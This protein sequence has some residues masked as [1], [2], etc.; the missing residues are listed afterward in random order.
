MDGT[1]KASSSP[2]TQQGELNDLLAITDS[3]SPRK[4]KQ[5]SVQFDGKVRSL[6]TKSNKTSSS[7][8]MMTSGPLSDEGLAAH[9][10]E[11][12]SAEFNR[13]RAANH[14]RK[15]DSVSNS[16]KDEF[17]FT[18]TLPKPWR[19]KSAKHRARDRRRKKRDEQ[20]EKALKDSEIQMLIDECANGQNYISLCDSFPVLKQ[21]HTVYLRCKNE[22]GEDRTE[23]GIASRD[24][25]EVA[26]VL[27]TKLRPTDRNLASGRRVL[28]DAEGRT[29]AYIF[30]TKNLE[31]RNTF[32]ICGARPMSNHHTISLE[33]GSYIWADVQN[34][35]S[36][37][38]KFCLT[39]R[40]EAEPTKKLV[41]FKTR[42]VGSRYLSCFD[43][44]PRTFS[45]YHKSEEGKKYEGCGKISFYR[46]SRGV[47]VSKNMDY[48]LMLCYAAIVDEMIE[49][50]MR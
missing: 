25:A 41:R 42:S 8:T 11:Q 20:R 26:T 16:D 14:E 6:D 23:L 3:H 24:G 4:S 37:S 10:D 32:K 40:K 50:R 45:I 13:K 46:D 22:I 18:N 27:Y 1:S 30:H 9:R 38:P 34:T 15:K 33:R 36:V 47:M 39:I 43:K 21:S 35:G 49:R 7:N 19:F 28:K 44:E 17:L 29:C 12:P 2:F 48:G 31:G 5:K